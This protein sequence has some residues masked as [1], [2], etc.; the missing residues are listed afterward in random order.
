MT[1]LSELFDKT[2]KVEEF[3]KLAEEA[4][5]DPAKR[6][7]TMANRRLAD[8]WRERRDQVPYWGA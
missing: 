1:I 3:Q 2:A 7:A 6:Y 5:K 8:L 4:S